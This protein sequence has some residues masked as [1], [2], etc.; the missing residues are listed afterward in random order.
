M[1]DVCNRD[2]QTK[3]LQDRKNLVKIKFQ[4]ACYYQTFY[5]ILIVLYCMFLNEHES[6]SN[7]IFGI[8]PHKVLHC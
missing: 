3:I 5:S 8:P 4:F 1:D 7:N 6:F 2:V